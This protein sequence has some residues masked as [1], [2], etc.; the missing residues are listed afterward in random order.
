LV[1]AHGSTAMHDLRV[2]QLFG[3]PVK[4]KSIQPPQYSRRLPPDVG[5]VKVN[6]DGSYFGTNPNGSIGFVLRDSQA[7]FVGAMVQNIGYTTPIEAEF[8]ACMMAMEKAKELQLT[9]L[10]IE[11]DS[12]IVV[13]A[14]CTSNGV[15]WRLQARQRNCLMYVLQTY[16]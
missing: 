13:K 7:N 16:N 15:P 4:I 11:T 1:L 10:W 8:C 12:L 14:F 3:I 6:C 9:H 2:S 5:W